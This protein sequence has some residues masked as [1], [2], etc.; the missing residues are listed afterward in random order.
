MH[1]KQSVVE[2]SVVG[3]CALNEVQLHQQV[4][5]CSTVTCDQTRLRVLTV[6]HSLALHLA[7]LVEEVKGD[8]LTR[9]GRNRAV[10]AQAVS[11]SEVLGALLLL[12]SQNNGSSSLFLAHELEV[13]NPCSK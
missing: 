3:D 8:D 7:L 11:T 12:M 4:D 5:R 6:R 13:H 1:R 9:E 2:V 10:S